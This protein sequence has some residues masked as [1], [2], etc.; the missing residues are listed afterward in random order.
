MPGHALIRACG[1]K[2]SNSVLEIIF[3]YVMF[4][5]L[6]DSLSLFLFEK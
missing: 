2:W 6:H 3:K 1:L 4:F 5:S